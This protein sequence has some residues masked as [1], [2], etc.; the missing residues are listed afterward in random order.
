MLSVKKVPGGNISDGYPAPSREEVIED[1][2]FRLIPG[3]EPYDKVPE[4]TLAQLKKHGEVV[5]TLVLGSLDTGEGA[6]RTF[7]NSPEG[8]YIAGVMVDAEE[9][10]TIIK[11]G[12]SQSWTLL[13]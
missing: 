2:E 10:G 6:F 11:L 5:G 4:R 3:T 1:V 12:K 9:D 7:S 8:L 13:Q